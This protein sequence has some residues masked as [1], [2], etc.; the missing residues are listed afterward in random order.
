MC[1]EKCTCDDVNLIVTCIKAGL[2]VMPNTLNPRLRTIIYKYNNFPTVDVSLRYDKRIFC[3]YCDH[4]SQKKKRGNIKYNLHFSSKIFWN[5]LSFSLKHPQIFFPNCDDF[6]WLLLG[7]QSLNGQYFQYNVSLQKD[8]LFT[9][10]T[11]LFYYI[12]TILLT[13]QIII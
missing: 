11:A 6:L 12:V 4:V 8:T 7:G 1:P 13:M 5:F 2:E 10:L 9:Y 3:P